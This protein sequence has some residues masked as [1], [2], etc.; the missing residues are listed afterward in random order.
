MLV[1]AMCNMIFFT[2]YLDA[3]LETCCEAG[4]TQRS[5]STQQVNKKTV[6][7]LRAGKDRMRLHQCRMKK[8]T[9]M[10][11]SII[12]SGIWK[13]VSSMLTNLCLISI[14]SVTVFD[15]SMRH[16]GQ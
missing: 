1:Q 3:T 12:G 9:R 16:T 11:M 8:E 10:G 14:L 4:N 5:R 6:V 2:V 7:Y 15:S 13:V